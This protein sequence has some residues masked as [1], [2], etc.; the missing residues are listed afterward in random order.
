MSIQFV[1]KGIVPVNA[2]S[3]GDYP[4]GIVNES[5][6]RMDAFDLNVGHVGKFSYEG[7]ISEQDA[8]IWQ[9]N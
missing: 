9:H 6:A 7:C 3:G 8:I 1:S 2:G 4:T 5:S